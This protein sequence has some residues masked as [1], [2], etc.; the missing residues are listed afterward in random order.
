M[1]SP[2]F[3]HGQ[4]RGIGNIDLRNIK[5]LA[6]TDRESVSSPLKRSI[7]K[8]DIFIVG[9]INKDVQ[10]EAANTSV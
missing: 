3:K 6:S 8:T 10:A 7:D 2:T 1:S 5:N 9:E 4:R